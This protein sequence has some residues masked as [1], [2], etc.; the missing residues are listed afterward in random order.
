MH[1]TGAESVNLLLDDDD[2]SGLKTKRCRTAGLR[3][4]RLE[5]K[6]NANAVRRSSQNE[7]PVFVGK[8]VQAPSSGEGFRDP[9][10][11]LQSIGAGTSHRTQHSDRHGSHLVNLHIHMRI[12]NQILLEQLTLDVA[13]NLGG[14]FPNDLNIVEQG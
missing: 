1:W 4:Q 9:P 3:G 14:R 12:K 8:V 10:S 11:L 7:D 5:G 2:I 13:R 6:A